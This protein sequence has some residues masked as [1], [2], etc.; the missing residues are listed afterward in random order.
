[1]TTGSFDRIDANARIDFPALFNDTLSTKVTVMSQNGGGYFDNVVRGEDEGDTEF[2][3]INAQALW[4]PTDMFEMLVSFD[5]F[6][7]TTP[8]RPV[9]A[10]TQPGEAFCVPGVFDCGAPPQDEDFHRNTT[11]T[12]SQDAFVETFAV[13]LQ[14]RL[15]INDDHSI[16][17]VFGWRDTDEDAIQEFDGVESD[18]F[19]TQRPQTME[20]LSAELRWH[21]DWLDGA[22]QSVLGGFYWDSSYE[23]N[24]RTTS[25]VFFGVP[26]MTGDIVGTRP[27]FKQETEAYAVFGQVDWNVTDF[28]TITAGGR[29][30]REEKTACGTQAFDL[31]NIGITTVASYG[32]DGF[33]LCDSS[34]PFYLANSV[35]PLTGVNASQESLPS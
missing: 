14:P 26:M 13:T 25:P 35:N 16:Q 30:L 20:Q 32:A 2:F 9:T 5:Y 18:I 33:F 4:E 21:G 24:Q 19:A 7:D 22:V 6:D 28:I 15:D 27:D 8:T 23:L 12:L 29:W 17:G 1:M 34:D 31:L 3:G 11:T 10:L